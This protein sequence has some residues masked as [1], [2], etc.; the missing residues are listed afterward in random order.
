MKLPGL[1]LRTFVLENVAIAFI[2]PNPG[3]DLMEIVWKAQ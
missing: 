3:D 2:I 1:D